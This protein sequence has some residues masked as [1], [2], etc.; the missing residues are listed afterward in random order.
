MPES[1]RKQKCP[2]CEKLFKSLVKH[3]PTCRRKLEARLQ[4][5]QL[6]RE[7][8]RAD[9]KRREQQ[10][11][12]VKVRTLKPWEDRPIGKK[13]RRHSNLGPSDMPQ[14][15]S[16]ATS[17][18]EQLNPEPAQE[19][20]VAMGAGH[21][22]TQHLSSQAPLPTSL[23]S[24]QPPS[25]PHHDDIRTEYHPSSGRPAR[26]DA[27]ENY[28][29]QHRSKASPPSSKH[30]PH[31]PFATEADF[32]FGELALRCCLNQKQ[33]NAFL[34]LFHRCMQGED[35]LTIHTYEDL[36]RYWREASHLL[37]PIKCDV[38][39]A[40]YKNE[41]QDFTLYSRSLWDWAL[42]LVQNEELSP[43]FEWDAQRLF[44][45]D[46][47]RSRWVRFINEPWT[48]D[49][50]Y[51]VQSSLPKEGKPLAFLLYADKTE[52]SSFGGEKGYPVYARLA[53]LPIDIRNG[54][55]STLGGGRVVG[56]L[57]VPK[58]SSKK[59]GSKKDYAD[60]KRVVWHDS[61]RKLL[62]SIRG[63]AKNGC[64]V[65]CGDGIER[66]LFPCIII[67][68]A[69]YEEQCTMANIRGAGSLS[70]C[71]I[72]LVKVEDMLELTKSNTER[73][74]SLTESM[75]SEALTK[76]LTAQDE[77]LKPDGLRPVKVRDRRAAPNAFAEMANAN[78]FRAL[79]FDRLHSYNN[80]L[81]AKHLWVALL[82]HTEDNYGA[83]KLNELEERAST[84][85]SWQGLNRF[86]KVLS[87]K[88]QDGNKNEDLMK[89]A[90]F[91]S[92]NIFP[93]RDRA[94]N[95]LLKCIRHFLNLDTL[96]SFTNHTE[97]T[98]QEISD[99]LGRFE[100]ALKA[101]LPLGSE[102]SWTFPKVHAHTHLPRD[103]YLKGVTRN[104][105]TK[106]NEG[107]HPIL[108]DFY[109]FMTNF[110]N[111]EGKILELEHWCYTAAHIRSKIDVHYGRSNLINT[112]SDVDSD[113]EGDKSQGQ[114]DATGGG[115][116]DVVVID[117][118]GLMHRKKKE[119]TP[120]IFGNIGLGSP[121]KPI[122][123]ERF[124]SERRQDSRFKEFRPL[125]EH[126]L[127]AAIQNG[128]IPATFSLNNTTLIHEFC[129]IRTFYEC[130]VTWE[131][132]VNLLRCNPDYQHHARYDA[133]L[134]N[135]D[136]YI[137]NFARLVSVF[138]INVPELQ[139]PLPLAFLEIYDGPVTSAQ[140]RRD[141]ELGLF[142]V[143]RKPRSGGHFAVVSA[144]LIT[145]GA[146][147]VPAFGE[148]EENYLVF[149]V[150]D[151]DM[152]LR[153]KDFIARTR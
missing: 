36:S 145:R 63:H 110:K 46:E 100:G 9:E 7:L 12:P 108:K 89:V 114:P 34:S 35:K 135:T 125:L 71:P 8:K 48:A 83:E 73:D 3:V 56:W 85:P 151:G 86:K 142:R 19:F 15:T 107:M 54:S 6:D 74:V 44:K 111:F 92:F 121:E 148:K 37:T 23:P 82:K 66:F 4:D 28:R 38:I 77:F 138:T 78:P 45:Y 5:E 2:I 105:N 70:P 101:S 153:V 13:R 57:P 129:F 41:Q 27:F 53:N 104:Y 26:H 147:L 1:P 72:C 52:L 91:I 22:P 59:K 47:Q 81:G 131:M 30:P 117:G 49:S 130:R 14:E 132:A 31:Y 62:D 88:Y 133:A 79:S 67:L 69:D 99:E 127:S 120:S 141:S 75:V 18:P 146:L 10:G 122:S 32:E 109:L 20:P 106:P 149:D 119:S 98:I 143:C 29:R 128:E 115:P 90:L 16:T 97:D 150:S 42:D 58:D 134:L 64:W 95:E 152:F 33:I 144:S 25:T 93:A 43:F 68:S 139:R 40:T 51:D 55:E 137:G 140:R 124:C 21:D 136:E 87:T 60:W 80:G 76:G 123:L 84:F 50:F 113:V 118:G 126:Y 11:T 96:A 103:I 24:S 116:A 17:G 61:F 65:R 94:G 39:P 102:G 112:D